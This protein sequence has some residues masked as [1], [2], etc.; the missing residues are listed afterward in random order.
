MQLKWF[1][2]LYFT[3]IYVTLILKFLHFN[4]GICDVFIE[5]LYTDIIV[6]K[7]YMLWY[8]KYIVNFV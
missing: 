7:R 8:N 2:L 6:I 5:Y 4:R 3:F 1:Y